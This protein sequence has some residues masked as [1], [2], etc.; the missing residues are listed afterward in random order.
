MA[1]LRTVAVVSVVV[2]AIRTRR[3]RRITVIIRTAVA[4]VVLVITT[5]Y[6]TMDKK[7]AAEKFAAFGV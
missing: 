4:D 6:N 3:T 7:K 5:T 1:T 2:Q